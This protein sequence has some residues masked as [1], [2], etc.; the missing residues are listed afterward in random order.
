MQFK[1]IVVSM[2]VDSS[3]CILLSR[4][5]RK[6]NATAANNKNSITTG[7]PVYCN[8][9][10]GMLLIFKLKRLVSG[11]LLFQLRKAVS[12]KLCW[13]EKVSWSDLI[14][15]SPSGVKTLTFSRE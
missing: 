10:T 4:R 6:N 5:V 3:E 15:K 9:L 2:G 13:P 7:M 8:E 11:A 12:C 1:T 14:C